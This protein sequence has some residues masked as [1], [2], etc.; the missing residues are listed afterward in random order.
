MNVLSISEV[1]FRRFVFK[2]KDS[3]LTNALNTKASINYFIQC[4]INFRNQL[5]EFYTLLIDL[6]IPLDKIWANI[7]HRTQT[8]INSFE[9]NQIYEYKIIRQISSKE[10]SLFISMFNQ[11]AKRKNIRLAEAFRLKAYNKNGILAISYIKQDAKFVC[12]NIYRL[13][14]ERA[15][16][17]YSFHLKHELENCYNSSHFGR[18]HRCLHWL[19]IKEFKKIG[20]NYYDFCGWYSGFEDKALLNINAFKEQ[21][22]SYKVLEYSGVIY[23]NPFLNFLKKLRNG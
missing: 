3:F 18:A 4:P 12:V 13:T 23:N 8:E 20:I 5:T 22:T 7:Y 15:T 14:K 2:A 21:F 10:L 19:D 9:N 6:K 16:N 17:L 11:F 1:H